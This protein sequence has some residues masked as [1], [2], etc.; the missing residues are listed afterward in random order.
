MTWIKCSEELP[1]EDGLYEVC[2]N[3]KSE[4][5][6]AICYYDGI[7]FKHLYYYITLPGYWRKHKPIEKHYGKITQ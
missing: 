3:N 4:D 1:S 6:I 5:F 2:N 7:G